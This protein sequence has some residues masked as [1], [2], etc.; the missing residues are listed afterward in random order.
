MH[1]RAPQAWSV[2][3]RQPIPTVGDIV[4]LSGITASSTKSGDVKDQT[5]QIVARIDALLAEA[6]TN[7]SKLLTA[8]MWHP[9]LLVMATAA[10]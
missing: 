9:G 6:A 8:Q 4:Y 3:H 7:E 10:I 2:L 1:R 5:R